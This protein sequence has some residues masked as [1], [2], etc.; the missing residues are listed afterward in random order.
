MPNSPRPSS[1]PSS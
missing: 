1:P